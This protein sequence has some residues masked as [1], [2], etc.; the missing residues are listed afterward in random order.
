[1]PVTEIIEKIR[2]AIS[3]LTYK[4]NAS[5]K[6]SQT[7]FTCGSSISNSN[8]LFLILNKI[9][10]IT[11]I[12]NGKSRKGHSNK[13]IYVIIH[14]QKQQT[15]MIKMHGCCPAL[16]KS[17]REKACRTISHTLGRLH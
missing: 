6:A 14:A 3:Y 2:A 13:T 15:F 7:T 16:I 5:G 4:Q 1:M 11:N 10:T 8:I 9:S 17:K 12:C